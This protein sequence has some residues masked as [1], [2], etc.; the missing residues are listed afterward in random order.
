SSVV[1]DGKMRRGVQAQGHRRVRD[2][3]H[4]ACGRRAGDAIQRRAL[5]RAFRAA[6]LLLSC[7]DRLRHR[8]PVRVRYGQTRFHREDLL[9][10]SQAVVV[11]SLCPRKKKVIA[12]PE[13]KPPMCAM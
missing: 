9:R 8:A 1:K 7:D 11:E 5:S 4:H 13:M 10:A 3:R 12:T 2:A 6:E